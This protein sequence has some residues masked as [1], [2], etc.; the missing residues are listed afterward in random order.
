MNSI[1]KL[2]KLQRR[3]LKE[4]IK[5]LFPEYEFVFIKLN[6]IIILRKYWFSCIWKSIHVSEL[7]ITKIPERLSQFR[8]D[9]SYFQKYNTCLEYIIHN[10]MYNVVDW[11]YTE[12]LKIKLDSRFKTIIRYNDKLLSENDPRFETIGSIINQEK[13]KKKPIYRIRTKKIRTIQKLYESFLNDSIINNF[14]ET[15][16]ILI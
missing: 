11:L 13:I 7:C 15:K 12:F 1:F 14:K 9:N 16:C 5:I 2:K 4:I 8:G 6:G 3:K 10:N